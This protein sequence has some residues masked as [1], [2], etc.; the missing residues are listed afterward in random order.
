MV[1]LMPYAVLHKG[2]GGP[3]A[4]QLKRACR[5]FRHLTD[6]DA[7]RVAAGARGILWRSLGA[8]EAR[9]L[10]R[11]LQSE[12]VDAVIVAERDLPAL[13]EALSLHRLKLWTQALVVYDPL[14]RPVEVDWNDI[15]LLAAGAAPP[16]DAG[17]TQTE[18][19]RLQRNGGPPARMASR[20]DL[21]K[22]LEPQML[23]EILVGGRAARYQVDGSQFSF[24]HVI[25]RPG[26]KREEKF[27]W[28]VR[29]ICRSAP[30][31]LRNDGARRLCAGGEI[32]PD[33]MSRQVLADEMI[34]LLWQR[35]RSAPR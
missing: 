31:A 29:E 27:I 33:Y 5:A 8:D 19:L 22:P 24:Q 30:G 15:T 6:A 21:E 9:A 17:K 7:S 32:V 20:T 1:H 3:S 13:P 12:G 16:V 2:P 25:D 10:C 23:L 11:A 34:W 28:L 18:L 26:L 35:E 14:G 4:D